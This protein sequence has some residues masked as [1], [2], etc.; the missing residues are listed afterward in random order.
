MTLYQVDLNPFSDYFLPPLINELNS[1]FSYISYK[2]IRIL[3]L[4]TAA[5][6]RLIL[7]K[8]VAMGTRNHMLRLRVKKL[9]QREEL[10]VDITKHA[11]MLDQNY[12]I[13]VLNIGGEMNVNSKGVVYVINMF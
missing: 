13:L 3:C 8:S 9:D 11:G 2:T 10:L 12:D 4:H 1:G 7:T 6:G 5:N